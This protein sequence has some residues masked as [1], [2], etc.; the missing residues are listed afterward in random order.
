MES[1][2]IPFLCPVN[3]FHFPLVCH[4]RREN[5]MIVLIKTFIEFFCLNE[6]RRGKIKKTLR[7]FLWAARLKMKYN[8]C[9]CFSVISYF[10]F[11]ALRFI[12]GLSQVCHRSVT[13]LSQVKT[14][15][16]V[17]LRSKSLWVLSSLS[18]TLPDSDLTDPHLT[19]TRPGPGP[20]LEN[21][22]LFLRT[23]K[24]ITYLD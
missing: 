10:S 19:L 18:W 3:C 7:S 16:R 5:V 23:K 24:E 13:G 15:N 6:E 22:H 12:S 8:F 21:I 9:Q 20:E 2:L 1:V 11:L 14:Q 17:L 4:V